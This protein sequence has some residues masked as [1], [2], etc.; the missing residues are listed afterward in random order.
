[1]ELF[2]AIALLCQLSGNDTFADAKTKLR[3]S[4]LEVT[5]NCQ[6]YYT[7][8]MNIKTDITQTEAMTKCIMER[9]L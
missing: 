1:M 8:C 2:T 7:H 5:L 6:Q 4:H 3:L 9:K